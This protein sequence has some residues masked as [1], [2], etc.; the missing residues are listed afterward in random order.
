MLDLL[1]YSILWQ[2]CLH[3]LISQCCCNYQEVVLKVEE[4]HG[5]FIVSFLHY[6]SD[7]F[8]VL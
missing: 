4:L 5:V 3:L 6:S 8:D 1:I 2:W 7:H